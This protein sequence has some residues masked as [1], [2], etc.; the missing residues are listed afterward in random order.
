MLFMKNIDDSRRKHKKNTSQ[1]HAGLFEVQFNLTPWGPWD[2][3]KNS[4]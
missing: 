3:N 2:S 4:N 1:K